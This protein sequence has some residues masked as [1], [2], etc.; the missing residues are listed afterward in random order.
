MAKKGWVRNREREPIRNE[1]VPTESLCL[2]SGS[3]SHVREGE[4]GMEW[5]ACSIWIVKRMKCD[6]GPR[7]N[8]FIE[9][10]VGRST[11]SGWAWPSVSCSAEEAC[12]RVTWASERKMRSN[13]VGRCFSCQSRRRN[14]IYAMTWEDSVEVTG[15]KV[16]VIEG[17]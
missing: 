15:S 12:I 14:V 9:D 1:S 11:P 10:E 3:P 6:R 16:S 4:M 2:T 17:H 5:Q 8:L 7:A 13:R